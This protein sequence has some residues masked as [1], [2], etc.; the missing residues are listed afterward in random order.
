MHTAAF[1]PLAEESQ[2]PPVDFMKR[3]LGNIV[4]QDKIKAGLQAMLARAKDGF[5]AACRSTKSTP[6]LVDAYTFKAQG[7]PMIIIYDKSGAAIARH[8]YTGP[9]VMLFFDEG[10]H[11]IHIDFVGVCDSLGRNRQAPSADYVGEHSRLHVQTGR[12][13]FRDGCGQFIAEVSDR[14]WDS[15]RQPDW[16]PSPDWLEAFRGGKTFVLH[17]CQPLVIEGPR[18]EDVWSMATAPELYQMAFDRGAVAEWMNEMLVLV[19]SAQ[20][21]GL[22]QDSEELLRYAVMYGMA[23]TTV[24]Q[25]HPTPAYSKFATEGEC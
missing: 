23:M 14:E 13:K 22:R 16:C 2:L 7:D 8:H 11:L 1:F 18:F 9:A 17:A 20:L 25:H 19:G 21:Q 4:S 12:W 3:H 6:E 24:D 10:G 15:E 5:R